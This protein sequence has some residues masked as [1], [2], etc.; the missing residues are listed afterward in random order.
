[1]EH[2][3]QMGLYLYTVFKLYMYVH[4]Y[5]HQTILTMLDRNLL[6]LSTVNV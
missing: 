4:V 6:L 5:N 1:M 2:L 3:D